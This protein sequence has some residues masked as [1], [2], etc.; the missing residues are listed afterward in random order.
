MAARL[1]KVKQRTT[2]DRPWQRIFPGAKDPTKFINV[3]PFNVVFAARAGWGDF[4]CLFPSHTAH[5]SA[6]NSS[7]AASGTAAN[8]GT[9]HW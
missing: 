4:F 5:G 7:T 2:I 9:A 1:C 8:K 3:S 6:A